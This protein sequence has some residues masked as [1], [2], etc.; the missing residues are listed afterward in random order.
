MQFAELERRL[1]LQ[2]ASRG[3]HRLP[4]PLPQKRA[5]SLV[6]KVAAASAPSPGLQTSTRP[7]SG[8]E[9]LLLGP[10]CHHLLGSVPAVGAPRGAAGTESSG[11]DS[12]DRKSVV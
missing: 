5:L 10:E 3:P 8:W 12:R 4:A 1:P 9:G 7:G 11:T 2:P 6:L